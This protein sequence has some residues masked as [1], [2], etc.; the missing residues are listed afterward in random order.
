MILIKWHMP[1]RQAAIGE[2]EGLLEK[3]WDSWCEKLEIWMEAHDRQKKDFK[4][5]DMLKFIR[6][7]DEQE[8][9]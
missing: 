3:Q 4:S 9:R 1:T 7:K 2:I 8:K 5:D 6:E